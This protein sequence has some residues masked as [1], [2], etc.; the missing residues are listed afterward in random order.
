MI[1]QSKRPTWDFHYTKF[2]FQI[3]CGLQNAPATFIMRIRILFNERSFIL[4]TILIPLYV[5]SQTVAEYIK[6]VTQTLHI[7]V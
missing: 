7:L 4:Y 1:V 2:R 3:S 6:Q 5:F